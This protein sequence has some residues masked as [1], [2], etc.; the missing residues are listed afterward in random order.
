M[1]K[2]H[3]PGKELLSEDE[4]KSLADPETQDDEARSAL[5]DHI[6]DR[7]WRLF[8]DIELLYMVLSD[9]ELREIFAGPDERQGSVRAR[10]QHVLA[11]FYYGLQLTDDDVVYRITS[12]IEEAEAANDRDATVT[13]DIV[14]QP[15]L[16]PEQQIQA[17]K[18]G[19]YDQV[20]VDAL[21]R[22]WYDERVPPADVV[23]AFAALGEDE[24]TVED[25]M[26]EREGAAMLERMPAPV[27]TDVEVVSEPTTE[28]A[29]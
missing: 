18:N 17:L 19:D 23:D 24:L 11:F 2:N 29:N 5:V 16:P 20:S 25:V 8:D 7:L 9:D 22:L 12:A 14:T 21:D 4:R 15:F 28:D 10:A 6:T 27:I 26:A 1:P 3:T 13:L